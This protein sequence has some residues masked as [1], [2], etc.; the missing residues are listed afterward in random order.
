LPPSSVTTLITEERL[1]GQ[2]WFRCTALGDTSHLYA[3]GEAISH[4]GCFREHYGVDDG[5]GANP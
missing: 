4:H 2:V 3:A 1:P 5:L